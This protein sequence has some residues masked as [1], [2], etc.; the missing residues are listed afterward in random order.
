L[1]YIGPYGCLLGGTR[2]M[3]DGALE[4]ALDGPAQVDDAAV[5]DTAVGDTAVDDAAVGET[6]G[7]TASDE[8]PPGR[9]SSGDAPYRGLASFEQGDAHLFFGREDVTERLVAA[10]A[11][12]ADFHDLPLV[13]VGSSGAGKSSVLRAGLLPRLAGPAV[14]FEPTAEPLAALKTAQQHLSD[15]WPLNPKRPAL[16][17][18]QFEAL[19]TACQDEALRHAF[20]RE[21]CELT[22]SRGAHVVI[23]LRADFYDHV[24]RYAEF[25]NALQYRQ[26]VLGPMTADD[27]TRA[28]TEPAR[29]ASLNVAAALVRLLLED[30][31][32]Q[33]GPASAR[34][35]PRLTRT[36]S[37]TLTSSAEGAYE[38]GAL[39]LLSHA[40]LATWEKSQGGTLT[41]A[42]YL[43]SGGIRDA[44]ARTAEAAYETL[45]EPERQLARRLFLHLVHVLDD[46][47]PTR[48][49]LAL[50]ELRDWGPDAGHVLDV[51]VGGRMITVDADSARISHD[52]LLTAWPRL[53]DWVDTGQAALITRRRIAGAAR[54]WDGA[55]REATWLWRG[56]QLAIATEWAADPA[57]HGTLTKVATEFVDASS[58][59]ERARQVAD[60][61]RTRR[62]QV[63][64]AILAVLVLVA[65]VTAGYAFTQRRDAVAASDSAS[66]RQLAVEAEQ[67][68]THDPAVG[69]QLSVASWGIAHT[70]QAAAALLESS[71]APTGA[72]IPDTAGSAQW[73]AISPNHALMAVAGAD[74]TLNLW[75]V[76]TPGTP[77]LVDHLVPANTNESLYVTAFS[78]DGT[79]LAAAGAGR[80]V[81]L[82]NISNPASPVP[83][84]TLTG[85]TSTIYSVAFSPHGTAV[86]A[87]SADG[88]AWLWTGQATAGQ[89][90]PGA[91]GAVNSVAFGLD[92]R[93]LA[94]GSADDK[95]RLWSL[96]TSGKP[97][98]ADTLSGPA[99]IVSGVAFSSAGELAAA[100][101]DDKVWLWKVSFGTVTRKV[102]TA[103][104][105]SKTVTSTGVQAAAD[106]TLTDATNA[107]IAVSFSPDGKMLAAGTAE[108]SVLVWT[109]AGQSLV[110][111]IP[112]PQPVTSVTWDGAGRVADSGADG[113]ATIWTLPAPVL[114]T[115]D[116]ASSVAYSPNGS[117]IA[118]GGTNVELWNA[119]THTLLATQPAP[120]VNGLS[121]SPDGR[122]LAAALGDGMV[123]VMDAATL[124]PAGDAFRVTASGSAESVAF[125]PDGQVLATGSDDGSVRWFSMADPAHRVLLSKV[126]DSGTPVYTVAFAPD[127]TTLAAASTDDETRLW[128][129][130]NPASPQLDGVPLGGLSSYAIA[131]AFTPDSKLLAV[132]SADKT[133]H[134]WN[135][136]NPAH[137]V[138][139]GAPL[140]GPSGSAWG[141]AISPDGTT[142]AVGSTDGSVWLWNISSP[143]QPTLIATLTGPAGHVNSVAFS[144]NGTQLA[145][146]SYDGTVHLWS[147][148][149]AAA[150]A[151]V[152]ASLGQPL[153]P[154][155]WAAYVPGVPYKAPCS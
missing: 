145:A 97:Q 79:T 88:N 46:A 32:P 151:Q 121:F 56:G 61:R 82:W 40:L 2:L 4:A 102:T 148:T 5:G 22:E 53:H 110:A 123:R 94:A 104:G 72:R 24:I 7:S 66:S 13:L 52:A 115:N 20:V 129:V 119:S 122:Y 116:K 23:A 99:D 96:A 74:G 127:G 43:A 47:P 50:A 8:R 54:A 124:A 16:I 139:V 26:V 51:F 152:C 134:L 48:A 140:T 155:Q 37:L 150:R 12:D 107:A 91:T 71:D 90:L 21:L 1:S 105:K 112:A 63:I 93:V 6:A 126:E 109:I 142:L 64:V 45:T 27:V 106:G 68:R 11:D 38:P 28:I 114:L 154:A 58:H 98:L 128:T 44:V 136:A 135:V 3:S 14:V 34:R 41:V 70:A 62:L 141:A 100:S 49:M 57:N 39:P 35:A 137:A 30:L 133:V 149:P 18:D 33:Q 17:V 67:V 143:S 130:S 73:V 95:V 55:G 131:L 144:P 147:T 31:T 77:V 146:S 92:G 111:R 132:G 101:H 108:G 84:P 120:G 25:A 113:S 125:S 118:V 85:P 83:L 29:Q 138:Q 80:Q 15:T 59:S 60:R 42:D 75:N 76:A 36:G 86:A 89:P 65:G 81:S 69:A 78:P 19:F 117:V 153:T 87:G 9:K 103:N 10:V